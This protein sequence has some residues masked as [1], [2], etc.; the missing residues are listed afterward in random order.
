M[1]NL[2][3]GIAITCAL[4]SAIAQCS[5]NVCE[6]LPATIDADVAPGLPGETFNYNWT[7]AV[8]FTGQGT[9]V[10]QIT[11]VGASPAT[12]VYT[13]DVTNNVTGCI[14]TYSCELVVGASVPVALNIPNYCVGSGPFDISTYVN[15]SGST[16][17]GA[18]LTGT[19]YD[20]AIGGP[21]TATPPPG[22]GCL[23][24][25]TQTPGVN[26]G[27]TIIGATVTQ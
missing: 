6:N 8:P 5:N 7:V 19:F 9:D 14:S 11:N 21:V 23:I 13:L 20:P 10:I 16:L 3:L 18:A 27:P 2:I 15:P 17:T 1:K 4:Q 25:S 22:S 12:I 24:A 26:P